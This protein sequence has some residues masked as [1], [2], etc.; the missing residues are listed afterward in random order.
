MSID[1]LAHSK[2]YV[3]TVQAFTVGLGP[4]AGR[5]VQPVVIS[6]FWCSCK[7]TITGS[8]LLTAVLFYSSLSTSRRG[9]INTDIFLT[10]GAVEPSK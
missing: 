5:V 3:V 2:S 4:S 7:W 1:N 8:V 10:S 6:K 9:S